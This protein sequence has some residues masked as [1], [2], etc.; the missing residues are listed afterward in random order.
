MIPE[1]NKD[2]LKKVIQA[3]A[4]KEGEFDDIVRDKG[5]SLIGLFTGPPGVGKTLTAEVMAEVAQKPLYILSS[6]DLG[7]DP[8]RVEMRL[9]GI[10]ELG[11]QWGAVLLLDEADVFLSKRDN[12]NLNRNAITS[13]FL[14]KLEY[15][16]GILFLTTNRLESIDDAFRSRIH[17]FIEY[18]DLNQSTRLTIWKLF[19]GV[20]EKLKVVVD[21][22]PREQGQLSK[23]PLNGRQIKNLVR[24]AQAYATQSGEQRIT[25]NSIQQALWFS[26]LGTR[27][28][29]AVHQVAIIGFYFL[30]ICFLIIFCLVCLFLMGATGEGV[31]WLGAQSHQWG[32]V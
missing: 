23:L 18:P 6:G 21:I 31:F 32:M 4:K 9:S 28:K 25:Y 3:H 17:I 24:L 7:E 22:N 8:T 30:C 19:F 1:A 10:L 14:R 27:T 11:Y 29:G 2:F 5:N 16:Q 12:Q 13:V 20:A 26:G 15:Y